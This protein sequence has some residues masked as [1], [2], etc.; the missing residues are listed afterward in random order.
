M[1]AAEAS[2]PAKNSDQSLGPLGVV[3]RISSVSDGE[4]KPEL[5]NSDVSKKKWWRV[6]VESLGYTFTLRFQPYPIFV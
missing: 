6:S 5:K 2:V 3:I 1:V 4:E